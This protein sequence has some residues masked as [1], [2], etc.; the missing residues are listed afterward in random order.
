MQEIYGR[1]FFFR[2]YDKKYLIILPDDVKK[3]VRQ[4]RA[5]TALLILPP[6]V[7]TFNFFLLIYCRFKSC[8]WKKIYF[9]Q[10]KNKLSLAKN[11]FCVTETIT[12]LFSLLTSIFY[13]AINYFVLS[14][15]NTFMIFSE[16][17]TDVVKLSIYILLLRAP[18]LYLVIT[19]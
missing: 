16:K 19:W 5:V 9:F 7:K 3:V 6:V 18:S 17:V 14:C 11:M 12:G 10:F 13:F 2:D 4:K 1:K 15:F 8:E